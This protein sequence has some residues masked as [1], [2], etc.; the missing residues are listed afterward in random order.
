MFDDEP[1]YMRRQIEREI[2]RHG[3]S[4]P[5]ESFSKAFWMAFTAAAFNEAL[6]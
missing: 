2:S 5:A 1:G 3:T 6:V 4:R